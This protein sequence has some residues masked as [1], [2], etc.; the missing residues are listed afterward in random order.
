M[1]TSNVPQTEDL[2]SVGSRISWSAIF[3]GVAVALALHFLF[4]VLAAAAGWSVSDRVDVDTMRTNA[5]V[6]MIVLACVALFAG[7]VVTT[8][9][10]AGENKAE[11]A[12]YGIVMWATVMVI[13]AHGAVAGRGAF[14]AAMNDSTPATN[15]EAAARNAGVPAD[16]VQ[17]W[18]TKIAENRNNPASDDR[19][20]ISARARWYAFAGIWLTMIATT[21]GAVVGAGPTFRVVTIA[22]GVT[23]PAM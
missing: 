1:A 14:A 15:W 12:I 23:R 6:W 16:Q 4:G 2:V 3:A 22:R 18:H 17:Q 5:M 10:T 20:E 9:L 7:G 21:V 13:I 8:Q 11:A 19:L